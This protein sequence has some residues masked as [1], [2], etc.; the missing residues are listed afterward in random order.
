MSWHTPKNWTAVTLSV[1]DM[2]EQVRD[3][4]NILKASI[5]DSGNISFPAATTLTLSSDACTVTQNVHKIDTQ[6]AAATDNLATLTIAGNIRAGHFLILYAANTAHVVTVKNGTGNLSLKG[7][8][9]PMTSSKHFII[10]LLVGTTW[11][12]LARSG[13]GTA[14]YAD[15]IWLSGIG[16]AA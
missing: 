16:S 11:F 3:N 10:L 6:A 8:D 12:E 7:G 15:P 5:D 1:V 9:F 14:P 2:N 4:E 13:G